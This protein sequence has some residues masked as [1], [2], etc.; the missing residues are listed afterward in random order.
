MN[1]VLPMVIC[2]YFI[3]EISNTFVYLLGEKLEVPLRVHNIIG[4]EGVLLCKSLYKRVLQSHDAIVI[5]TFKLL[6]DYAMF[7]K[8]IDIFASHK[9]N[10]AI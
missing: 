4:E 5:V 6:S 1:N 8:D 7:L 2:T 3:N 9:L 10:G